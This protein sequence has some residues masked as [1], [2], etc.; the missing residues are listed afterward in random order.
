MWLR[1][2]STAEG[3]S[4][5]SSCRPITSPRLESGFSAHPACCRSTRMS[6]STLTRQ[7]SVSAARSVLLSAD[8]ELQTASKRSWTRKRTS[9]WHTPSITTVPG[10]PEPLKA[11]QTARTDAMVIRTVQSAPRMAHPVRT[12]LSVE[13]LSMEAPPVRAVP[14]HPRGG[15]ACAGMTVGPLSTQPAGAI[16]TTKPT[17][18]LKPAVLK[19]QK[20]P[21]WTIFEI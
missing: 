7:A 13:A 6:S 11:P 18:T 10:T 2:S 20:P 3:C 9:Q 5:P 8:K 1:R 4:E 12:D 17:A 16:L 19:I 14:R 15:A 21:P